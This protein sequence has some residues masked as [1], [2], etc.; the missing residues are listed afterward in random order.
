[1]VEV[2]RGVVGVVAERLRTQWGGWVLNALPHFWSMRY[3]TGVALLANA[4]VMAFVGLLPMAI[5]G[6]MTWYEPNV[7]VRWLE[8]SIC[9]TCAGLG[10]VE[11]V[12]SFRKEKE[13][14]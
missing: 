7:L 13:E 11:A 6:S 10:V 4:G 3:L 8:F 12:L 1:M 5:H 2:V 9:A 14:K